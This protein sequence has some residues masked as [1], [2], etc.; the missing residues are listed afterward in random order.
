MRGTTTILQNLPQHTLARI[1]SIWIS[2][3]RCTALPS[4]F[5]FPVNVDCYG[6]PKGN[7]Y[8]TLEADQF[9][10]RRAHPT[11]PIASSTSSDGTP[12]FRSLW[13][14][15]LGPAAVVASKIILLAG[16]AEFPCI[17]RE[18]VCEEVPGIVQRYRHNY[19]AGPLHA[20]AIG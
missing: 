12:G 19:C 3:L 8:A 11:L 18:S 15:S 7:A 6:G 13:R 9:P 20:E 10:L 2:W 14:P 4:Q 5:G 1:E 17:E 16:I